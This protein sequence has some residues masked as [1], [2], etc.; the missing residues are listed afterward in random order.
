MTV[1]VIEIRA[2]MIARM[3][4]LRPLVEEYEQLEQ[5]LQHWPP[6]PEAPEPAPVRK[7]RAKRAARK[8]ANRRRKA[9][10]K[11]SGVQ[12]GP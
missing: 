5:A 9:T 4:E 8:T 10:A 12:V 2:G 11:P 1:D 7:P 3:K 6:P